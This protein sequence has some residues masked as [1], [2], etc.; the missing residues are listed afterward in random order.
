MTKQTNKRLTCPTSAN[1]L[2]LITS[3]SNNSTRRLL[4]C[5]IITQRFSVS[6]PSPQTVFSLSHTEAKRPRLALSSP[7]LKDRHCPCQLTTPRP[8]LRTNATYKLSS[9]SWLKT[10]TGLNSSQNYS[11][12]M[13][14][15]R[16]RLTALK[17]PTFNF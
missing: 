6:K 14:L 12:L 17:V 9:Q 3:L 7:K 16:L 5:S 2:L 8:K 4:A 15:N 10:V 1:S 13:L 11:S